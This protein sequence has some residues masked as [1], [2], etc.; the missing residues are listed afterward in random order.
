MVVG[1]LL[2]V[3]ILNPLFSIF[4]KMRIVGFPH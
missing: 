3:I 2:L 4:Q 1:L